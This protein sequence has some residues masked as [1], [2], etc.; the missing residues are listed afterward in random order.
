MIFEVTDEQI[1]GLNDTDLRALVGLL[2]E[3]KVRLQGHS[4]VSVILG[5]SQPLFLIDSEV[6]VLTGYKL[7]SHQTK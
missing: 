6:E 2:C 7:P 4:A 3:E 5:E 1:K